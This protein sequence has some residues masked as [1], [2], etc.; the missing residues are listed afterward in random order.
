MISDHVA[1]A[2][3]EWRDNVKGLCRVGLIRIHQD[4]AK[5]F[6]KLSPSVNTSRSSL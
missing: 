1:T 2:V 3:T 4:S 5:M 6:R